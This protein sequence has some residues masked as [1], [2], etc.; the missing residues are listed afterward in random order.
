VDYRTSARVFKKKIR[1]PKLDSGPESG[2]EEEGKRFGGYEDMRLRGWARKTICDK[3]MS[4]S[5]MV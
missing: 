4:N 3:E 5:H 2:G 1:G